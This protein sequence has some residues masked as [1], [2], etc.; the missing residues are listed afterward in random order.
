MKKK[1]LGQILK[2]YN[3]IYIFFS[4]THHFF[5]KIKNNIN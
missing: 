2:T 4:T 3:K 5:F 1:L